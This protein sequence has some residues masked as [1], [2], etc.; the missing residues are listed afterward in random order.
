MEVRPEIRADERAIDEVHRLAFAREDEAKLVAA[1]RVGDT[2]LPEL[3]LVA[4]RGGE[5]VG[6]VLVTL[7]DLSP[8]GGAPALPVLALAPLAVRPDSQGRGVGGALV[9][10][11]L[12]RAAVRA[13]PL[14]VV[15]G[16]RGYYSR[17]GFVPASTLGIAAPFAVADDALQVRRLPAFRSA[18]AGVIRYPPEFSGLSGAC[19]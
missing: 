10:T 13:E 8:R 11:A 19:G 15:L 1:L 16:D 4:L 14:V 18:A 5:V 17:F 3:S 12:R 9:E 7:V 2:Y 6:H